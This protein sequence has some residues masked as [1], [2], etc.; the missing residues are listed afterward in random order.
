MRKVISLILI[1]LLLIP[2]VSVYARGSTETPVTLCYS[3]DVYAVD[4]VF[5]VSGDGEITNVTVSDTNSF[6]DWHYVESEGKLYIALASGRA[7]EKSDAMAT[8]VTEG[9]ITLTKVSTVINGDSSLGHSYSSIYDDTC[10]DCG[11]VRVVGVPF[12]PG[13][14][15]G[16]GT[17]DSTDAVMILRNLAG[18]TVAGFNEE[19]A[20]F[21]GSGVADSTDAV[22]ILRKLAGYN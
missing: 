22:M 12:I 14:V 21:D 7:I 11:H 10:N 16:N 6:F 17:A 5:D 9:N 2:C 4:F 1:A 8:V 15:D 18:Y 3:G 13:D 20:D 19:A